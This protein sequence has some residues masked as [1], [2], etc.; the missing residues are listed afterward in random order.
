M[1]SQTFV[2]VKHGK[3]YVLIVINHYS[4][5]CDVKAV[6]DHVVKTIAM[7]LKN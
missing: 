3:I 6:I 5:W 2:K 7:F 4:K 1:C